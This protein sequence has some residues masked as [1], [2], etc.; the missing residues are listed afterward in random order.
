VALSPDDAAEKL[1][2]TTGQWYGV[3]Y[4]GVGIGASGFGTAK[5]RKKTGKKTVTAVAL[6]DG[7]LGVTAKKPVVTLRHDLGF[8]RPA[9]KSEVAKAPG[10]LLGQVYKYPTAKSAVAA[11]KLLALLKVRLTILT[12]LTLL[13]VL[14]HY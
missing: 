13:T 3:E 2:L 11:E 5:K 9:T 1:V 10:M 7:Y 8:L 4:V 14:R 6:C 12:L